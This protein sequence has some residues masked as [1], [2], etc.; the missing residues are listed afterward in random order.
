MQATSE[1]LWK[2]FRVAAFGLRRTNLIGKGDFMSTGEIIFMVLVVGVAIL[3]TVLKD[4]V[5]A[6]LG[7]VLM[8]A[9]SVVAIVGAAVTGEFK[10]IP[11]GA[12]GVIG[13]IIAW[14]AGAKS[15]AAT[16]PDLPDDGTSSSR[17]DD[18]DTLGGLA[19]NITFVPW[20]IIAVVVIAAAAVTF[21]IPEAPAKSNKPEQHRRAQVPRAGDQGGLQAT[22][23]ANLPGNTVGNHQQNNGEERGAVGTDSVTR[24]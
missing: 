15:S 2:R 6:W 24:A 8:L 3:V 7:F 5:P 10:A 23:D 13:T 1:S 12:A 19:S 11:L 22:V 16:N 9:A 4:K 14:V 20:L 21:V 17:P 18:P